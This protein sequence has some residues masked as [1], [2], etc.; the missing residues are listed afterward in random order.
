MSGVTSIVSGVLAASGVAHK[1][2][3][4]AGAPPVKELRC[5]DLVAFLDH[6]VFWDIITEQDKIHAIQ[7][8]VAKGYGRND[9][10]VSGQ[11]LYDA[12]HYAW[13]DTDLVG[14][15]VPDHTDVMERLGN[16]CRKL[17][18]QRIDIL[19]ISW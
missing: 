15:R 9:S 13:G 18:P 5:I 4:G 19:R 1:V 14:S 2:T 6:C 11:W 17:Y 8:I 12:E 7:H 3:A 16:E 10:Y